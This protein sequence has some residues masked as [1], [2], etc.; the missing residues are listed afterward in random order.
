MEFQRICQNITRESQL[1]KRIVR[2]ELAN[3]FIFDDCLR[4]SFGTTL[5]QND[6]INIV[7]GVFWVSI[8]LVMIFASNRLL[9][10]V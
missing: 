4:N 10:R 7:S 9:P 3:R 5:N 6:L 2:S 1:L 8:L